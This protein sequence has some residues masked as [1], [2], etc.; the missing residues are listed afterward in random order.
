MPLKPKYSFG[1]WWK[2][3]ISLAF[4]FD[5]LSC[6]FVQIS[7]WEW[8]HVLKKKKRKKKKKKESRKKEEK[9]KKNWEMENAE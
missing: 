2:W 1:K 7:L 3:K 4:R 5:S 6:M 9:K 8:L